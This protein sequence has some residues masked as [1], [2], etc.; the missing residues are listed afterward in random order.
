MTWVQRLWLRLQ[1]LFL[2]KG[3]AKELGKIEGS[4]LVLI[5]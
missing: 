2:R 5:A 1:S 4:L 3:L